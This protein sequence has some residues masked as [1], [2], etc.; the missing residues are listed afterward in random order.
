[1]DRLTFADVLRQGLLSNTE[2]PAITT[3]KII[4]TVC[5][6]AVLAIVLYF[7]YKKT[8][9]GVVYSRSFGISLGM[10]TVITSFVILTVTSNLILSLGMVG[11]L[12]IV[13]FRTAV[14]D[15][16]DILYMFWAISAGIIIGAGVYI[17]AVVEY[18]IVLGVILIL[19]RTEGITSPYL[20]VFT[21]SDQSQEQTVLEILKTSVRRFAVKSKTVRESNREVTVEVRVRK[22]DTTFLDQIHSSGAVSEAVLMGYNG[23]YAG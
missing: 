11:A 16:I 18:V 3:D 8:F 12:S 21:C 20:L 5:W 6:S 9:R 10:L 23:E 1:M 17:L 15:A 19:A 2:A 4:A 7:T 13:R 22:D 14:K